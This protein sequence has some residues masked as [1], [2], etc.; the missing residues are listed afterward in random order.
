MEIKYLFKPMCISL[1]PNC[2]AICPILAVLC[3]VF[4]FKNNVLNMVCWHP[5][6]SLISIIK[7]IPSD[8][9]LMLFHDTNSRYWFLRKKPYF[10]CHYT[11][12]IATNSALGLNVNSTLQNDWYLYSHPSEWCYL[13]MNS[14]AFL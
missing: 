10:F 2:Q 6:E 12:C 8:T 4:F 11:I 9:C 3:K 1:V 13:V 5:L 7:D 14:F